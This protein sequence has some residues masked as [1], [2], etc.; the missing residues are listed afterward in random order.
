MQ[1]HF[2]INKDF[3]QSLYDSVI[4]RIEYNKD[5]PMSEKSIELTG[6]K[7]VLDYLK[8]HFENKNLEQNSIPK[9]KI[10]DV[11]KHRV[12]LSNE[13]FMEFSIS[14]IFL[15]YKQK[16]KIGYRLNV[17]SDNPTFEKGSYWSNV[18]EKSLLQYNAI[19]L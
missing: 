3:F 19:F 5:N 2:L 10:G 12:S 7:A 4:E 11:V 1:P 9:F 13:E 14:K 18:T 17:Y 6:N 16:N 15:N 8:E